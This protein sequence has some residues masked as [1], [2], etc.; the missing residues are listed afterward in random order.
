VRWLVRRE[1][2]VVPA[3]ITK[4]RHSLPPLPPASVDDKWKRCCPTAPALLLTLSRSHLG[5]CV[6]SLLL[7]LLL[8]LQYSLL[9]VRSDFD[10]LSVH[11]FL[12]LGFLASSLCSSCDAPRPRLPP[13]NHLFVSCIC[14]YF[15]VFFSSN[16]TH[17]DVALPRPA[18]PGISSNAWM[19]SSSC[20]ALH[21]FLVAAVVADYQL[22]FCVV[23][24]YICGC[25]AFSWVS[26][27]VIASVWSFLMSNVN[28][29]FSFFCSL[30]IISRTLSY[31]GSCLCVQ[32]K[33]SSCIESQLRSTFM[34]F[35]SCLW[36]LEWIERRM[37]Q[38]YDDDGS[39]PSLQ[40]SSSL[41]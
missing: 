20:C 23:F 4:K 13:T 30:L 32:R 15:G 11:S 34:Q 1:A 24:I 9:N 6:L 36:F 16:T 18:W 12:V 17:E 29:F 2:G 10:T 33:W 22:L 8:L 21:A 35:G 38:Y 31:S 39:R 5:S 14:K 7:L 26:S 3:V 40:K 41:L 27:A 25:A 28:S 37:N 19:T